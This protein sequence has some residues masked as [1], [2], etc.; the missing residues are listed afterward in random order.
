[1]IRFPTDCSILLPYPSTLTLYLYTSVY[2][3]LLSVEGKCSDFRL[4]QD[5][6]CYFIIGRLV[7]SLELNPVFICER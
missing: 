6:S 7:C 2:S 4:I 1:M 5:E 3:L